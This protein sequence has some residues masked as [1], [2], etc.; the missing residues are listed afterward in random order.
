MGAARFL[1]LDKERGTLAP[2]ARADLVAL[3]QDLTV[4][5]T[6]IGGRAD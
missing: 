2:G 1:G 6:W 3:N 4:V 5:K